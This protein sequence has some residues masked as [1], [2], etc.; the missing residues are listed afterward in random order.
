MGEASHPGPTGGDF[1]R[2]TAFNEEDEVE[3]V[4]KTRRLVLV[5]NTPH[6]WILLQRPRHGCSRP[7]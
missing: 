2:F 4:P 7:V 3:V 6:S 1:G 5:S